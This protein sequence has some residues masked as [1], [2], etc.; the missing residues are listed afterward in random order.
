MEN[1]KIECNIQNYVYRLV[2]LENSDLLILLEKKILCV[3]L[4]ALL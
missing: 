1:Q 2:P 4:I 3:K